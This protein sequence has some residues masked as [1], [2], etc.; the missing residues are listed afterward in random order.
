VVSETEVALNELENELTIPDEVEAVKNAINALERAKMS[1]NKL[2]EDV[3]CHGVNNLYH[4][5]RKAICD[6]GV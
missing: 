3:N 1:M 2:A 5:A 6:N 4:A